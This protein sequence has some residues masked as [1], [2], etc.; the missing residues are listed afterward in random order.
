MNCLNRLCVPACLDMDI[1][2][3][4]CYFQEH[5]L[6]LSDTDLNLKYFSDGKMSRSTN[7]SSNAKSLI[8][9]CHVCEAPAP[10]HYHFGGKNLYNLLIQY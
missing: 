7:E 2:M 10:D 8:Y 3:F 6:L 1:S 5:A 9:K 4:Y